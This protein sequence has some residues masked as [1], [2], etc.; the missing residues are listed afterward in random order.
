VVHLNGVGLAAS[1]TTKMTASIVFFKH[2]VAKVEPR[3]TIVKIFAHGRRV[4]NS[5]FYGYATATN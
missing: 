5:M 4:L 1:G 3:P 2:A